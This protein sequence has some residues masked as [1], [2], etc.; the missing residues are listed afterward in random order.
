MPGFSCLL[1]QPLRLRRYLFVRFL[2]IRLLFLLIASNALV[3]ASETDISKPALSSITSLSSQLARQSRI[4]DVRPEEQCVEIT[5]A[6]A[7]CL[8]LEDIF[9]DNTRLANFSGLFWLLGT[10]GLSGTETVTI[11]GD[12]EHRRHVA[13]GLLYA[14]GQNQVVIFDTKISGFIADTIGGGSSDGFS[15]SLKLELGSGKKRATT[16]TKVFT[17][18][19]RTHLLLTKAE[20]VQSVSDSTKGKTSTMLIDGRAESEYWGRRVR[21][22]RGG[23]IPG[24]ILIE[25]VADISSA[26]HSDLSSV[27]R[28]PVIVY[29]H[30]A[31]AGLALLAQLVLSNSSAGAGDESGTDLRDFQV[32]LG[33]WIEWSA[34]TSLPVDAETYSNRFQVMTSAENHSNKLVTVSKSRMSGSSVLSIVHWVITSVLLAG[35]LYLGYRQRNCQPV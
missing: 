25:N 21:A 11:V 32:Y 35:L 20:V 9:A 5:L 17:E 1:R 33:G 14:A 6:G 15:K 13:A 3:A 23:H 4:I 24:A 18:L 31:A 34:D 8:P 10:L 27:D 30:D 2:A 7:V 28:A 19:S 29:G 16:R 12:S 22:L 26:L